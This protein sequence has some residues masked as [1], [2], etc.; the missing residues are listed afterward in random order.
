MPTRPMLD[1]ITEASL[2]QL[3]SVPDEQAALALDSRL[4][5]LEEAY[6]RSFVERGIILVEMKQRALWRYLVDP[7]TGYNYTSME[8]WLVTAAPQSRA[9]CFA[10]MRAVEELRDIP[11][12]QLQ[13][14][15]RCNIHV[16]QG[17]ST[18]VRRSDDV[19]RAARFMTQREFVAKLEKDY[20][21][22]HVESRRLIHLN[23]TR[24]ARDVIER[25]VELAKRIEGLRTREDVLEMWA[26]N[27]LQEHGE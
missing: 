16:L 17:L 15:P 14:I 12:E 19:M 21:Y 5:V 13:E 18:Q 10:A 24:G 1:T 2:V 20:P 11:R 9:D 22:Q 7:D 26:S 8:R 4:R 6:K 23:P 3:R 25:A 27:Y